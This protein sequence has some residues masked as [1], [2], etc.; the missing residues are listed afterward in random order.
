MFF[1]GLRLIAAHPLLMAK[2]YLFLD[3]GRFFEKPE[4]TRKLL[5]AS[6]LSDESVAKYSA[7]LGS[8]SFQAM[9]EMVYR[10][11]KVKR[12]RECGCPLLVLGAGEDALVSPKEVELTARAYQ[13]RCKIFPGMGHDMMLEDGWESVAEFMRRW[14][15]SAI[16]ADRQEPL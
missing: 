11:P 14:I 13:A 1:Q 3:P 12:I 9:S 2:V 15:E 7:R 8:E 5:F 10:L 6:A 4:D 16:A